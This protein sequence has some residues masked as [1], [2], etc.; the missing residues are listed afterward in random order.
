VKR[1]G[2]A[3]IQLWNRSPPSIPDQ[4]TVGRRQ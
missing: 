4:N 3:G 1:D 2:C